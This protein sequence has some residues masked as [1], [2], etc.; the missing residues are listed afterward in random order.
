MDGI[1]GEI[2]PARASISHSSSSAGL[3]DV[4]FSFDEAGDCDG[5]THGHTPLPYER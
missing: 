5:S 1:N 4:N 3:S 2:N